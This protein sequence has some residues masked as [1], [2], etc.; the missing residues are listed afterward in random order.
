M[1][2][3]ICSL[4][5]IVAVAMCFT[6]C[7]NKEMSSVHTY[8][9]AELVDGGVAT[10]A[11]ESY[12]TPMLVNAIMEK[13]GSKLDSQNSLVRSLLVLDNQVDDSK[14]LAA[15]KPAVD[16][17]VASITDGDI[18]VFE[19]NIGGVY[20]VRFKQGTATDCNIKYI[21]SIVETDK[22][23]ATIYLKVESTVK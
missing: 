20:S 10:A 12:V 17:V 15:I 2:K 1:K 22:V 6:G 21:I 16:E 19:D 11:T 23:A 8:V 18:K 14:A 3:M 5:A 7:E 13:Q 9:C 4:L